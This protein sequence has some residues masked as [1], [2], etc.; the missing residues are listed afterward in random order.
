MFWLQFTSQTAQG[1]EKKMTNRF[2]NVALLT[3]LQVLLHVTSVSFSV[4][5]RNALQ[6]AGCV[7]GRT[8]AEMEPTSSLPPAV[9]HT[10]LITTVIIRSESLDLY[11][12]WT[13]T[14]TM[15]R[16]LCSREEMPAIG[17]HLQREPY[18]VRVLQV[19]L[20]RK[21]WLWERNGRAEL[22]YAIINHVP[23]SYYYY[24]MTPH[25]SES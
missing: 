12:Y 11:Q 8:T 2:F 10:R 6:T 18:S 24:R 15:T 17:V 7:T 20:W 22:R 23:L 3:V 19:A 21:G 5:T 9:S 14:L 16:L 25:Q 1:C 4:G 13:F